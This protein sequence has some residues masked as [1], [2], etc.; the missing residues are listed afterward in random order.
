[1]KRLLSCA[2]A[3]ILA[4]PLST[5]A[6]DDMAR[7]VASVCDYTKA[8]DR[9]NLRKKLDGAGLDL[10]KVYEGISCPAAGAFE[11]GSLLRLAATFGSVDAATFIAAKLGKNGLNKPESDGKTVITWAE[12]KVAAGDASTKEL[13]QPVVDLLKS[14]AQ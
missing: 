5:F 7:V 11:G 12:A 13:M 9:G 8:N 4:S 6:A 14:K 10:R 2:L 3:G 1:M